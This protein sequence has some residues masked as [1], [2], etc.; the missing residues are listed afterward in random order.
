MNNL[1]SIKGKELVITSLI[2]SKELELDH[3]SVKK[4]IRT[5]EKQISEF[6]IVGFEIDKSLDKKRGRPEGIYYLN[7][8]QITFLITLMKNKEKVLNFKMK[9]VKEFYKMKKALNDVYIRQQNEEWIQ[10]RNTGKI[11]R[12]NQTDTIEKFVEYA[13]G[14]GSKN[15]QRYYSNITKMENKALFMLEQK[16]ENIREL[17]TGQQLMVISSADQIVE[18]ALNDGMNQNMSYKDIYIMAKE[19]VEIFASVLPKTPVIM[20]QE[21]NR[22]E[23]N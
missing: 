19:R 9:L 17:L 5:Y 12:K 11:S 23:L 3:E 8:Q 22:K 16:F 2:I 15:A 14:Q 18:K 1:V 13:I 21:I 20:L 6:G 7:E 4:L 10:A